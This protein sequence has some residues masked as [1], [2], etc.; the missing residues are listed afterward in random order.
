MDLN[1]GLNLIAF[2]T[3]LITAACVA[4][5]TV[6]FYVKGLLIYV[7]ILLNSILGCCYG[8][9]HYG[10]EERNVRFSAWMCDLWSYLLGVRWIVEVDGGEVDRAKGPYI[11]VCN[12]QSSLDTFAMMKVRPKVIAKMH[13]VNVDNVSCLHNRSGRWSQDSWSP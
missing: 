5:P 6:K 7:F 8:L 13:I 4:S 1:G 3:F 9:L 2:I 11:V 12:H 10:Q